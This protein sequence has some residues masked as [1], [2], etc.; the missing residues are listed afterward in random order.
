MTLN[1]KAGFLLAGA[2][3][4]GVIAES[5]PKSALKTVA[6]I[7]ARLTNALFAGA[8]VALCSV[9]AASADLIWLSCKLDWIITGD[10]EIKRGIEEEILVIDTQQEQVFAYGDLASTLTERTRVKVSQETVSFAFENDED[11]GIGRNYHVI[12]TYSIDRRN[13]HITEASQT[14]PDDGVETHGHGACSVIGP[15]PLPRRQ[16]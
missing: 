13:L 7:M 3:V 10:N 15:M 12:N 4:E 1:A 8:I 11:L 6:L 5:S 16:F 9:P 2:V 14:Y